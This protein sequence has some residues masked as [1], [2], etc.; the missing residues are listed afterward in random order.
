LVDDNAAFSTFPNDT[1][2]RTNR[3]AHRPTQRFAA[4]VRRAL[5]TGVQILPRRNMLHS[6]NTDS[7]ARRQLLAS[8]AHD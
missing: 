6:G 2:I 3:F 8:P 5:A 7:F 4:S 1:A